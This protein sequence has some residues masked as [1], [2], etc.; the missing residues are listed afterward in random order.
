MKPIGIALLLWLTGWSLFGQKTNPGFN[1]SDYPARE[2]EVDSIQKIHKDFNV[3]LIIVKKTRHSDPSD[4]SKIWLQQFKPGKKISE[5][6]L[7]ETNSEYGFY[8]P[9][10]QPMDK[11]F[12]LVECWEFNGVLHLIGED[13]QWI[14]LPGYYF[15]YDRGKNLLFTQNTGGSEEDEV[16]KFDLTTMKVERKIR[17]QGSDPNLWDGSQKF[18]QVA[19][20]D[21]IK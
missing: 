5:Q 10:P 13:G 9:N 6:Y 7:G 2:Y 20:T 19:N 21:W 3:L 11:F 8:T 1:P 18:Y 12:M 16:A 15:A 14:D 4:G 17:K